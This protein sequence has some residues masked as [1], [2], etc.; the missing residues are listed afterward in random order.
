MD[1]RSGGFN[2]TGLLFAIL[3]V[4]NFAIRP[5]DLIDPTAASKSK[6]KAT[7]S[8]AGTASNSW[9]SDSISLGSL[10][11]SLHCLLADSSTLISWSW[12]GFPLQ[13]PVPSLHGSLTHVAQV[14]G[15]LIPAVLATTSD[16]SMDLAALSHPAW[17]AYGCAS[18]YVMYSHKD[19]LGYLGGLNFSVFLMS[20]IP[21]I[22]VRAASNGRAALTFFTAWLVVCLF[23]F[24]SVWTV[25]YAFVPGGVYLRE[26]TD[27]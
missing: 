23:D 13:G 7:K 1:E 9:L 25:A 17:L 14:I 2:K 16:T 20:V 6:E 24:A 26:R 27:L 12:T 22:C 4:Y 19:W 21:L 18:A 10:I 15:L 5:G 8:T 11:F 3:A